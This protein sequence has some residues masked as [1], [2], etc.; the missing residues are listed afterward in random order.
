[1]NLETARKGIDYVGVG[2]VFACHDGNGNFLFAKRGLA[3]RDGH[4]LWEIPAGALEMGETVE[5]AVVRELSEELCVEPIAMEYMGYKDVMQFAHETVQKHWIAFEFLVLVD[6]AKVV[7]GEPD[8]CD[9]IE[10][11]TLDNIPE[12]LHY[13]TKETIERIR[14]FLASKH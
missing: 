6:P 12:A 3:A 5:E 13:G 8:R 14:T 7:I 4:G 10:W 9:G 11:R 2:V 1:M